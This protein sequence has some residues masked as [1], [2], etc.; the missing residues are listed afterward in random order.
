MSKCDC[1]H[2]QLERRC[3]YHITGEPVYYDTEVSVCWGTKERD[4]CSCNGDESKCDFYPEAREK[5]QERN[6]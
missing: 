3:K 1:Y 2:T 4:R 5:G 6:S